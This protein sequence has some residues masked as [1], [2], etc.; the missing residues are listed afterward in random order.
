MDIAEA[1]V[2]A[3]WIVRNRSNLTF[4]AT[5]SILAGSNCDHSLADLE[6]HGRSG[7]AV[8][9]QRFDWGDLWWCDP[10]DREFS[11]QAFLAINNRGGSEAWIQFDNLVRWESR[12]TTALRDAATVLEDLRAGRVPASTRI[13]AGYTA[14]SSPDMQAVPD[15]RAAAQVLLRLSQAN[16]V[17][18]VSIDPA[19]AYR[20]ERAVVATIR[21]GAGRHEEMRVALQALF[22][23]SAVRIVTNG[24]FQMADGETGEV[25]VEYSYRDAFDRLGLQ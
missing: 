5:P 18:D 6:G 16:R 2:V 7:N 9:I 14:L 12:L 11:S 4:G 1:T 24:R 3:D 17:A 10:E 25:F 22:P 8:P 21:F 20:L 13:S 15:F 19:Q 23:R